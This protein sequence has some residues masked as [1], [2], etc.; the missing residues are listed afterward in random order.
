MENQ[1]YYETEV[2]WIDGRGGE[3]RAP[4]LPTLEV[5]PPPEF[6]GNECTWTP[7]HMYVGSVNACFMSTFLAIAGLSKLDL[8]SFISSGVGKL[9]KTQGQGYSITE[10]VLKPRLIIG[11]EEDRE[12]AL[13]ALQKAEKSCFISN[14]I[15]TEIKLEPEIQVARWLVQSQA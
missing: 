14:S 8:L 13:R 9:E 12:K 4:D 3:L 11:R 7:E 2:E 1:Y 6:Q 10:V 15:K 5:S